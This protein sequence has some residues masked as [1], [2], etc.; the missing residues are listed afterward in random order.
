[1]ESV[2]VTTEFSENRCNEHKLIF[3]ECTSQDC[4]KKQVCK[5]CALESKEGVEHL[6]EHYEFLKD[7]LSNSMK[8]KGTT[9]ASQN[10]I[11]EEEIYADLNKAYLDYIKKVDFEL[12]SIFSSLNDKKIIISEQIKST[13]VEKYITITEEFEELVKSVSEKINNLSSS[14]TKVKNE[15]KKIKKD[16]DD[17]LN[18]ISNPSLFSREFDDIITKSTNKL[19]HSKIEEI[20]VDKFNFSMNFKMNLNWESGSPEISVTSRGSSYWCTKSEEVLDGPFTCKVLIKNINSSNADSHWN[21]AFGLIRE[22]GSNNESSYYNDCVLFQSNGYLPTQFSGSGNGVSLFTQKWKTGDIILMKRDEYG[23]VFFGINS[24]DT[25][26]EG[27]KNITGRFKICMGFST[28]MTGDKFEM[29]E[30]I[31][32]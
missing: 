13:L 20:L 28:S 16:L 2:E 22:T 18:F 6:N 8:Q 11:K 21:Y 9:E 12:N 32:F 24:E 29:V 15:I 27:F 26:K 5:L 23:N 30:L 25:Y 31:K 4:K 19:T 10:L 17:K 7:G 1:M 3:I 14:D